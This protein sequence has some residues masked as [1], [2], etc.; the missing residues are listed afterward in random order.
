[1]PLVPM[2]IQ[3]NGRGERSFD[4]YSRLLNERVIFLGTPIDDEVAN[5]VVAQLLHLEA[6]DPDKEIS[7]YINCPGGVVYSG[8][9]I[10]DTMQFIGPD[11]RTICCGIAMSMGSLIL[12]GGR[13]GQALRAAELADP[14][15][16]AQRRLPGPVDRHR[17]PRARDA[18]AARPARRDLRGPHGPDRR[19]GARRHGPRPVLHLRAGGRVRARRQGDHVAEWRSCPYPPR[20]VDRRPKEIE[21]LQAAGQAPSRTTLRE[22]RRAVRPGVTT[23]ELDEVAERTMRRHG[24]RSAPRLVYDFPGAICISVDDE[25]VHGIPGPRRLREGQLVKIDVTVER[26][27]Y[28]ADAAVSVPV[29]RV[30]PGV[31]RLVATAQS[32][33]NEALGAVRPGLTL[34]GA[35]RHHRGRRRAPRRARAARAHGHGIGRTIHEGPSVPNFADPTRRGPRRGHGHHDRA[36]H[37]PVHARRR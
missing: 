15:P 31:S 18:R 24:A 5:L 7:L 34:V 27:G 22:V 9:A 37:R 19:E 26:N 30:K 36:D 12:A 4:I 28:F 11:V 29:G 13:R 23:Q 1:M 21:G 14:H 16:P 2:V 35:G 3:D 17:D 32:A 33:L 6:D 20:R 25:A 10:Y 8:L